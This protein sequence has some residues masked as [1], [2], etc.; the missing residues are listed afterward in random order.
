MQFEHPGGTALHFPEK[1]LIS[2]DQ[3]EA[4]STEVELTEEM[5][6][7]ISELLASLLDQRSS[8]PVMF[9][10]II[11]GDTQRCDCVH[12]SPPRSCV[13]PGTLTYI[14]GIEVPRRLLYYVH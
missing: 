13:Y 6:D 10:T 12:L 2:N 9:H 3:Y 8:D 1:G 11:S 5:S 4:A 7:G 14:G